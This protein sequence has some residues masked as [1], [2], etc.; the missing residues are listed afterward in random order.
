MNLAAGYGE[1]SY[2]GNRPEGVS[3]SPKWLIR[4]P[5]AGRYWR[6]RQVTRGYARGAFQMKACRKT[7]SAG[8]PARNNVV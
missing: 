7:G 2:C 3:A 4:R 5:A 1:Y 6:N 8:A